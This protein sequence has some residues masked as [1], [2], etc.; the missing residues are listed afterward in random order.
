[1]SKT[2][3]ASVLFLILALPTVS[4]AQTRVAVDLDAIFPSDD[5]LEGD[6]GFGVSGRLG[7]AL[8]TPFL[9]IVPELQVGYLDLGAP[10]ISDAVDVD[11]LDLDLVRA[12]V[13]VRVGWGTIL[14]PTVYGHVG[15]GWLDLNRSDDFFTSRTGIREEDA[16]TWDVG[17][18]LDL[19]VLPLVDVGVHAAYNGLQTDEAL[20]WWNAGVHAALAF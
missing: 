2:R 17:L 14:R 18:A 1:M 7:A 4:A 9:D 12:M 11:D 15:W 3:L 8:P 19:A 13:G 20:N 10:T 5:A 6:V 16:M